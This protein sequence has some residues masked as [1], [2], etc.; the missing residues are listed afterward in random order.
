MPSP[1]EMAK[2]EKKGFRD[3]EPLMGLNINLMKKEKNF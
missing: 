2:I 3:T 1:E